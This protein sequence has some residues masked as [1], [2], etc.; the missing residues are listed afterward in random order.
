MVRLR[1]FT[2]QLICPDCGDVIGDA[3]LRPLT[4]WL[5]VRLAGGG[6][7]GPSEGAV[8]LNVAK[9]RL[10]EAPADGR[11]RAQRQLAFVERSL[12]EQIYDLACPRGHREFIT[13]PQIIR[14]MHRAQGGWARLPS[15]G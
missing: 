2:K 1:S 4:G 11:D 5:A 12:G 3:T 13:A 6:L 15:T 9:R 7:A 8:Q 10:T 14:A